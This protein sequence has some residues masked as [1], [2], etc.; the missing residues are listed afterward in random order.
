MKRINTAAML[1]LVFVLLS[2]FAMAQSPKPEGTGLSAERLKRVNNL[3]E[4]RIE[5]KDISG[6]VTLVA[7]R[8]SIAHLEAQGLMD[9]ETNKPMA[10]DAI[11]R[12]ASMTKPV[13]GVAILMLIEEGKVRL[14][15]PVSRFIPEFKELKV[16]VAQPIAAPAGG[17]RGAAP[18]A[19]TPR[20]YVVPAE[21]EIT[22]RDL[23]TH[24]SGLGSGTIS[25]AEATRLGRKPTDTLADYIPRLGSTPLE[26]Q[27]GSRWAYSGG[28]GFDTLGRVVEIASGMPL[29]RFFQQRIFE[30]LGMKDTSFSP[31]PAS[32]R[33]TMYQRTPTGL[34]KS[35]NQTSPNTVYFSGGGG[36]SSTA[37]DYFKF[38]QMLVNGGQLNGKRLLS[39]RTVELM[40]STYIPDTLQGRPRGESWGLSVRVV[41]DP[42][43]RNTALSNGSFGWSGAFGTHFWVD[44]KEKLLAILMVQTS[45]QE[46]SRDFE[47]AVMQAI[48]E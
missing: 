45:N 48:V 4:R 44:P 12:I 24:T 18:A 22:I 32:R 41:T 5:A 33:V 34:Q 47:A 19:T 43:A 30:P 2:G 21:R 40:G 38:A 23:L 6:A 15:D 16:A 25:N 29:D 17:A 28:A 3:I 14:S 39:P 11:F 26:F 1:T 27:P 10:K 7:R 42:P 13:V 46:M 20:F 31:A 36:L 8:G 35:Q 9:I 37:E